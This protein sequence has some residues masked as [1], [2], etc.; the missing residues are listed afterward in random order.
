MK[1]IKEHPLLT[2]SKAEDKSKQTLPTL[3]MPDICYLESLITFFKIAN[4]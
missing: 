2:K 1:N 4:L 3:M